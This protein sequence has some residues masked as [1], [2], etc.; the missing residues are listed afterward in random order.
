M[1]PADHDMR[2]GIDPKRFDG[3][4]LREAE[5]AVRVLVPAQVDGTETHVPWAE[6]ATDYRREL[7]LNGYTSW[8][9]V[10]ELPGDGSFAPDRIYHPA[11]GFLPEQFCVLLLQ[12]LP[13]PNREQR[14]HAERHQ[15][16]MFRQVG[17]TPPSLA[18]AGVTT[19]EDSVASRAAKALLRR[20]PRALRPR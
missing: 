7:P 18:T 3:Y 19:W 1:T 10:T 13:H 20:R 5:A 8:S 2:W 6:V 9:D 12:A 16:L 11:A 4:L 15:V 17:L 14:W